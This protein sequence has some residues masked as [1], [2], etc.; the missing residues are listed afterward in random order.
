MLL[1]RSSASVS[2][3]RRPAAGQED[4]TVRTTTKGAVVQPTRRAFTAYCFVVF[5]TTGTAE[6]GSITNIVGAAPPAGLEE[7]KTFPH[8]VDVLNA[9][10]QAGWGLVE[11]ER[12]DEAADAEIRF[13]FGRKVLT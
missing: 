13:L 6:A 3:D 1:R 12:T 5:K 7:R 10:G 11:R 4:A 8:W 2:P 9:A